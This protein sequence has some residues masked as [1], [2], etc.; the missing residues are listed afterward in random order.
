MSNVG[1]P[2]IKT[3]ILILNSVITTEK[4]NFNA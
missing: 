4:I 1:K 3:T 2:F